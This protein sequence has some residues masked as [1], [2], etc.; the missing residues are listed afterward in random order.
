L[1]GAAALGAALLLYAHHGE[2]WTLFALL[3]L[4]PDL[5]LAGYLAGS[6]VGAA[7]Y[8]LG[9]SYVVP[10]VMALAAIA[11]THAALMPIALIWLAHI[12]LDRFLGHG[13]QHPGASTAQT[14]STKPIPATLPGVT[15]EASR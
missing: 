10:L 9:H 6:R 4:A 12:S 8:N 5:T 1:E 7:I 3:F 11:G 15:T 14:P 13:L 2:S